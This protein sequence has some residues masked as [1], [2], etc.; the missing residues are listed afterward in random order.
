MF[1]SP[2]KIK[3]SKSFSGKK[4]SSKI[5]GKKTLLRFSSFCLVASESGIITN[6]QIESI[7]RFLR[8]FLK[9]KAQI[10]FRLFPNTPITKKPNE[11]RLGRGKGKL[12]Y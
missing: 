5:A 11:V 4:V 9:K 3:F 6:F 12:K 7:R 10:F 2:K 8:R 1:L